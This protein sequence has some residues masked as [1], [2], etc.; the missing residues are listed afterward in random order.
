MSTNISQLRRLV[1]RSYDKTLNEGKG[2]WNVFTLEPDDLGQDT[3][4]TINIAPRMMSRA[5][6]LGTSETPIAGTLDAFAASVTFLM[7][8]FQILG[9]ALRRW[10]AS[11][12]S[13][14]T[15]ADGQITDSGDNYCNGNNYLSVIA[16][17]ICDDGSSADI[18]LS[19]C[20]PSVDDDIEIGGSDATE[21]TLNLHPIIYNSTTH[22]NDGYPAYSYRMGDYDT[23]AKMRLDA[24]TGE[25]KAVTAPVA[26]PEGA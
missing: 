8:N 2:G 10:I 5:S 26:P 1:F 6:S 7:D 24:S 3:I 22:A 11:T 16:Q 9:K 25:Y 15:A 21:V 19:R 17:G 20:L 23:T 14:A 18:E 12:Y 13:A 4:M